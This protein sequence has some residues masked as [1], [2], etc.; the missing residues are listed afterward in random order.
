MNLYI[1]RHAIAVERGTPGYEDDSLRPLTETGR[2]KMQKIARGLK[3]LD[4]SIDAILASPYVRTRHTAE[5]LSTEFELSGKV[6]FSQNLTPDGKIE[7][8]VQEIDQKYNDIR[9]LA[10]VGHEPQLSELIG[11]L[12]SEDGTAATVMKKGGVCCLNV[13]H[14]V[15]GHCATLEWLAPPRI[16]ASIG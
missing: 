16:L 1:I 13:G 5:V 8:L 2:A 9:N 15:A 14:L 12:I 10:I 4:V 6:D 3:A 11:L 7:L